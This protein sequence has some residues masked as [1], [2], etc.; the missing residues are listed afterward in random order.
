[1][2]SLQHEEDNVCFYFIKGGKTMKAH[3][4]VLLV[5]LVI[6]FGSGFVFAASEEATLATLD[7]GKTLFNDPKLG[8]VGKSCNTC[9]KDGKGVEK[10]AAKKDLEAIINNC[11]TGALK[12]KALDVKS[13]DM[14]SLVL[15]IKSFAADKKP[16]AVKKAPVGC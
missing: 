12:G 2:L 7:K 11:I 10:A 8:T 6:A 16:A 15:Y 9:H 3:K 5:V 1:M 14:Q 13:A 4:I